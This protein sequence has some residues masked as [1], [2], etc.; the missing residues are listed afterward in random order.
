MD[1]DIGGLSEVPAGGLMDHDR[2]MGETVTFAWIAAAEEEGAH[3]GCLADADGAY[4][5]RDVGHCVVDC[6]AWHFFSG[7]YTLGR[8]KRTSCY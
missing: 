6:K 5:G 8:E 2:G 1:C 3:G 7:V 4:G